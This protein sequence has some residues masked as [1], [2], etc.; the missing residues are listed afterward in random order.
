MLLTR[1]MMKVANFLGSR[2]IGMAPLFES[3]KM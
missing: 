3:G 2:L 1:K